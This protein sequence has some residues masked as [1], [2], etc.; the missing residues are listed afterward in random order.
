MSKFIRAAPGRSSSL[1]FIC[2]ANVN[3]VQ[4]CAIASTADYS[5]RAGGDDNMYAPI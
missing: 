1:C 4:L 2:G 5:H 3:R